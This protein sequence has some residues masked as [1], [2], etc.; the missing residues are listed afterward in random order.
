MGI[1]QEF[2]LLVEDIVE[3]VEVVAAEEQGQ[4]S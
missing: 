2:Q 1:G 4:M 3:E